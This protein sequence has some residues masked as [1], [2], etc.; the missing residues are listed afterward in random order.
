LFVCFLFWQFFHLE[1]SFE[2]LSPIG[3]A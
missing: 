1:N 3:N 2:E